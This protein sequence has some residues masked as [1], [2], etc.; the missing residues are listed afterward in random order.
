[1]QFLSESESSP[2]TSRSSITA[3]AL[4]SGFSSCVRFLSV[5]KM[6]SISVLELLI[7]DSVSV[8]TDTSAYS[9]STTY[10]PN[11]LALLI[12]WLNLHT[13]L[14]GGKEIQLSGDWYCGENTLFMRMQTDP[15]RFR[16][17]KL[18]TRMIDS[19]IN[20]RS[21]LSVAAIFLLIYSFCLLCV[22]ITK[23]APIL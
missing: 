12:L 21:I 15:M 3:S 8:L 7:F 2:R 23:P 17:D 4:P 11:S 20:K 10:L 9:K 16:N 14:L 13:K 5:R 6:L 1:M 19:T 18:H 22:G